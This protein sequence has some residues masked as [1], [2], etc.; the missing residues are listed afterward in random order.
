MSILYLVKVGAGSTGTHQEAE[1]ARSRL[2]R[3]CANAHTMRVFCLLD[4]MVLLELHVISN[5]LH[6]VD[7]PRYPNGALDIGA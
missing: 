3:R 1:R 4:F 7:G 5:L 2:Q 6:A